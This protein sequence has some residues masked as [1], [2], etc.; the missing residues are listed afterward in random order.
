MSDKLVYILTSCH[1]SSVSSVGEG[2]ALAV[3]EVLVPEKFHGV[4]EV[5]EGWEVVAILHQGR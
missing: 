2:W 5:K 1:G 4:F 3:L